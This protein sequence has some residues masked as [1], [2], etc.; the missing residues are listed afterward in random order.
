MAHRGKNE[1]RSRVHIYACKRWVFP[2]NN[3][4]DEDCNRITETLNTKTCQYAVVGKEIS[5]SGT[6]HLQGF[7]SLRNKQYITFVKKLVGNR[8][9]VEKAEHMLRKHTEM[10]NLIRLTVSNK[11]I[12]Y[13][14]WANQVSELRNMAGDLEQMNLYYRQF[15]NEVRGTHGFQFSRTTPL[16]QALSFN[17]RRTLR[18]LRIL[19]IKIEWFL[20]LNVNFQ[21]QFTTTGRIPW[22]VNYRNNLTR[23]QFI[24]CTTFQEAKAKLSSKILVAK[25]SAIRFENAKSADVKH[26]YNGQK[27]FIF[28]LCRAQ[29]DHVNY[30]VIESIKNGVM[31]ASK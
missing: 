29:E 18:I 26:S 16:T 6:P 25:L 12:N 4:T 28:D 31:F 10:I 22:Y 14:R 17:I 15:E 21:E 11:G 13:W 20:N 23:E 24:G 30:E 3:Y 27:I 7:I 1:P 5:N 8:A 19:T 9:Y 2:L